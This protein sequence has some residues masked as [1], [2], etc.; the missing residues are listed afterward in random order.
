ME[1]PCAKRVK[2]INAVLSNPKHVFWFWSV[3]QNEKNT[4]NE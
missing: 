1:I 3:Y 2:C 4:I